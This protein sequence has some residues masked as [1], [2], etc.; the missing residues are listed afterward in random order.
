MAAM[1]KA[2]LSAVSGGDSDAVAELV[3]HA[4]QETKN[5]ALL[6]AVSEGDSDVVAEFVGYVE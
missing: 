4:D 3:V 6:S 5:K 1:N 2:L